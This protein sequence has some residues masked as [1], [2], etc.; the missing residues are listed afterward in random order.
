MTIPPARYEAT[1]AGGAE[2]IAGAVEQ[3]PGRAV[4]GCPGW[5]VARLAAHAGTL[6]A[7]VAEMVRRRAPE[8]LRPE[9]VPGPPEG[10]A[11]LA[12]W[13]RDASAGLRSAL[14]AAGDDDPA[15]RWR[16]REVTAGFWRRRLA[17]ELAVHGFDAASA[18][19]GQEVL[20]AEV[21][22][23]GIDEV[24]ELFLPHSAG[25]EAW[26]PPGPLLLAAVDL[27]AGW[28]LEPGAGDRGGVAWR[29]VGEG[30]LAGP[31]P[32]G[33]PSARVEATASELFLYCWGRWA[34][35]AEALGDREV[36]G[37]WRAVLGW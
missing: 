20:D 2:A 33:G 34:P 3:D 15:G 30:D 24:C 9:E 6:L 1:I 18:L 7:R 26:P 10:P 28:V 37:G 4:P 36:L 5:D 14:G 31:P 27:A 22:A 16:D 11:A 19:G 25:K 21:S 13:L 29:R 23:D 17:H 32:G 35:E 8:G 12:T